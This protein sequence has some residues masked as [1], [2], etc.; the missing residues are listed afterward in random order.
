MDTPAL[1]YS[2]G[3]RGCHALCAQ[4]VRTHLDVE[5]ELLQTLQQGLLVAGY[6]GLHVGV[7]GG[8]HLRRL[9]LH[10]ELNTGG[11]ERRRG[12]RRGELLQRHRVED[13]KMKNGEG[14]LRK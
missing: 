4:G 14:V 1:T 6:K 9:L 3:G 11:A 8:A 12:E 13:G 5:C 7:D 10:L 2:P